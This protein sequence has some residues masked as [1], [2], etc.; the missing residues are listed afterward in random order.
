M[1]KGMEINAERE[2]GGGGVRKGRGERKGRER[3]EGRGRKGGKEGVEKMLM[4]RLYQPFTK[5]NIMGTLPFL[6]H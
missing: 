4:I 2:E 3:R 1:L 5:P 6:V